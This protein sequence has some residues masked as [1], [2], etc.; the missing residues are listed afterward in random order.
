MITNDASRKMHTSWSSDGQWIAFISVKDD[1]GSDI[2]RVRPDGTD[3]QQL[4]DTEGREFHVKWASDNKHVT[5]DGVAESGVDGGVTRAIYVLNTENGHRTT[6]ATGPRV[7]APT[8]SLDNKTIVFSGVHEGR[9]AI[10]EVS[11]GQQKTVLYVMPE[12]AAGGGVFFSPYGNTLIFHMQ[13][14]LKNYGLYTLERGA[15]APVILVRP[16]RSV[17]R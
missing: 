15:K 7:A 6:V 9:E 8:F 16:D 13:D 14:S 12:G 2:Y 3:L 11:N 4:T 10:L 17:N 1:G 5:Y